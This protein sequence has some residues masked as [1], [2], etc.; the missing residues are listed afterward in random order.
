M[1]SN[2]QYFTKINF[3]YSK[4]ISLMFKLKNVIKVLLLIKM[5]YAIVRTSVISTANK[6][7]AISYNWTQTLLL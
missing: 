2:N 7:N 3:D 5:H 4:S 1:K 6:E